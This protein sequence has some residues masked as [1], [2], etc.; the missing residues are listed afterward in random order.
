MRGLDHANCSFEHTHPD[1]ADEHF[2]RSQKAPSSFVDPGSSF[3][4]SR[5]TSPAKRQA[6]SNKGVW[7]PAFKRTE[8]DSLKDAYTTSTAAP[9]PGKKK[10]KR[11]KL[12]V[13]NEE[14]QPEESPCNAEAFAKLEDQ[15]SVLQQNV[16]VIYS[17]T[18]TLEFFLAAVCRKSQHCSA[19][20]RMSLAMTKAWRIEQALGAHL[21]MQQFCRHRKA[22]PLLWAAAVS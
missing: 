17:L 15:I 9:V 12:R 4:Q 14:S 1:L 8:Q 3:P 13:P 18:H 19:W 10:T 5:S 11:K 6:S 21:L 20:C 22:V 7:R 2:L 16:Q